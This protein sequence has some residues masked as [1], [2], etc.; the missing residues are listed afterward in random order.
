[1]FLS[2]YLRK[3]SFWF[4]IIKVELFNNTRF[5]CFNAVLINNIIIIT[6]RYDLFESNMRSDMH[7]ESVFI[8]EY[9][10]R[11]LVFSS[12]FFLFLFLYFYYSLSILYQTL[13]FDIELVSALFRMI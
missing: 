7:K 11:N 6:K 2:I 5:L 10:S 9:L 8:S 3:L 4:T 13:G 1:M 12:F